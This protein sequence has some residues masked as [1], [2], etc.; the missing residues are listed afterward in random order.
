MG[1]ERS[2]LIEAERSSETLHLCT[3]H[4]VPQEIILHGHRCELLKFHYRGVSF[5]VFISLTN[6]YD[7]EVLYLLE[8]NAVQSVD[9]SRFL[10][11]GLLFQS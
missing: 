4:H 7:F 3:K 9:T 10:L 6:V 2:I 1:C 11:I 5:P 8:Y